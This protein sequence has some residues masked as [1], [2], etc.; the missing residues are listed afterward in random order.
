MPSGDLWIGFTFGGASFLRDERITNYTAKQGLPSTVVYKFAIDR[1]GSMWAATGLGL[2]LL[3]GDT[4]KRVGPERYYTGKRT[5]CYSTA[6]VR[7]GSPV[8]IYWRSCPEVK[9]V[10]A[11]LVKGWISRRS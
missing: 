3:G 10:F 2:E 8:K 11:K 6:R 7:C 9:R 1:E 5:R 4:W